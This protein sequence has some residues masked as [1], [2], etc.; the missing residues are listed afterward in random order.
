MGAIDRFKSIFAPQ[1]PTREKQSLALLNTLDGKEDST[2][3]LTAPTESNFIRK[4]I[5]VLEQLYMSD[6][7]IFNGINTWVELICSPGYII[8]GEDENAVKACNDA[9]ERFNFKDLVLPKIAQHCAICGNAYSEVLKNRYGKT[10]GLSEPIDPKTVDFVR[11]PKTHNIK[12]DNLGNP[13]GYIQNIGFESPRIIDADR[14]AHFKLYSISAS[15][16]GVGF[17]EPIYWTA[18]GK[19]N[20]DEKISQQEFRRATPFV[21]V[22]VGDNEHP[23]TAEEINDVHSKIRNIT[24]KTDFVGPPWYD[25]KFLDSSPSNSSLESVKYMI[26]GEVAGLGLPKTLITGIGENENR[27]VLDSM[28]AVTNRRVGRIQNSISNVIRESLFKKIVEENNYKDVPKMRWNEFSPESL[29]TK[30]SR[31]AKEVEI[32]L[33]DPLNPKLKDLVMGWENIPTMKK[34]LEELKYAIT[35]KSEPR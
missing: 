28:L 3:R 24:Y 34:S 4:N 11:D 15:Q 30:I 21:H 19:R 9:L 7:I 33:I 13:V 1:T 26:D 18:L 31:I 12:L 6:G 25:F 27:A 5:S 8:E 29:E 35:K 10:I 22:K 20:M 2:N 32:G 17:I 14:M 23:P 16:M